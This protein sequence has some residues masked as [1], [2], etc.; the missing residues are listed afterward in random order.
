MFRR[1][2]LGPNRVYPSPAKLLNDIAFAN[3]NNG[4]IAGDGGL[5]LHTVNA[6]ASWQQQ[7]SGVFARLTSISVI[8]DSPVGMGGT[9]LYSD[10]GGEHWIRQPA[11]QTENFNRVYFLVLR[12]G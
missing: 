1:R 6:G 12:D 5:I 3:E 2:A 11:D 9:I 7:V 4:W 8:N 10:Y